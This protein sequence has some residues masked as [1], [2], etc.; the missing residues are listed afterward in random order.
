MITPEL[1]PFQQM[2]KTFF[3]QHHDVNVSAPTNMM[4]EFAYFEFS[5]PIPA[6]DQFVP[7]GPRS[8]AGAGAAGGRDEGKPLPPSMVVQP[9][10][11]VR[12]RA[13]SEV[14]I[15]RR[16]VVPRTECDVVPRRSVLCGDLY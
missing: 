13:Y 6:Y 11:A 12:P 9:K 8:G 5:V 15:V 10:L 1:R 3:R 14:D 4:G 2:E 7:A 16:P